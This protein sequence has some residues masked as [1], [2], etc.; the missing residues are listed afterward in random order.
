MPIASDAELRDLLAATKTVAVLG[1]KD[2]PAEDAYR[3]PAYLQARGYRILPVNPKLAGR[4]VLGVRAVSTL[5]ELGETP[6]L[7][8]VFRAPQYV[9]G[10]ADEILAL[11]PRPRAV[12]LQLGIRDDASARRLEAAGIAVVQDRCILVEHRR[13]LGAG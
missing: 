9:A 12:W 1:I 13:L 3:V 8:D 11:R 2:A 4:P 7:V 5:A 6:D 10:H